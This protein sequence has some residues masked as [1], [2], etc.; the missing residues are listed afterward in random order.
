MPNPFFSVIVPTYNRAHLI[1]ETI[2]SVLA[3]TFKDFEL[4]IV[5]DGS[6]DN[7]KEVIKSYLSD[8]RVIYIYQENKERAAARNNGIRNS[9]GEWIALLDSDDLWLPNH[10]EVSFNTIKK[11]KPPALV[12]SYSYLANDKGNIISKLKTKSFEGYVLEQIIKQGHSGFTNSS[13]SI[14]KAI[15]NDVGLFNED[16]TLSGSEDTELWIRIASKYPFY[17]TGTYTVKLRRHSQQTMINPE[18]ME[19]CGNRMYE[20]I[21]V[22]PDLKIGHLKNIAKAH[23]YTLF[24]INYYSSGKMKDARERLYKAVKED[25]RILLN[26]RWWWIWLRTFIP[27]EIASWLRNI[28]YNTLKFFNQHTN[29]YNNQQQIGVCMIVAKYPPHLGGLE[30]QAHLL[31]KTLTQKGIEVFVLTRNYT[32]LK[33]DELVD[34]V[35]IH[36]VSLLGTSTWLASLSYIIGS[37]YWLLKNRKKYNIIHCHQSYSPMSIGIIAK[38]FLNKPVIVKLTSSMILSE[39]SELR[40]L[41]LYKIRKFFLKKVDKF[42]ALIPTIKE[43]AKRNDI[44]NER[45][46][47]IPNGVNIKQKSSYYLNN[48]LSA[49]G[50]IGLK[51]NDE[52]IVIFTG[53]LSKEKG[54]DTL[55]KAW[56][57]ISRTTKS[58]LFIVGED[59]LSRNIAN[60]IKA[61]VTQFDLENSVIFTGRVE[62]TT[63]YLIASDIFVLP[64]IV[65]GMSN[66]LLEAMAAGCAIIAS[67]IEPNKELIIDNINGLLFKVGNELAL[68]EKLITLLSNPLLCEKLGKTAK[69]TIIDS[70]SIDKVADK[71]IQLY[72]NLIDWYG[73]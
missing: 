11:I 39:F 67:D 69:Q 19:K 37:L 53:R 1:S 48:K 17:S 66:S 58:K 24:A 29:K 71:Y 49:R 35:N 21:F 8:P 6:T 52:K 61:L 33:K 10:L 44:P 70:Y 54:L 41:P 31:S 4:I 16:R 2:E 42:I 14:H 62:D 57:L 25:K 18:H 63:D 28:K 43:E 73:K 23:R 22:N 60:E 64:S 55:I 12:Y 13:S 47:I 27:K 45:V 51:K 59:D 34:G 38:L 72:H 68:S 50:A 26:R 7:T 15:L 65:E 20:I 56:S 5:D 30:R 40:R 3:Q 32:N 46:L 36:R 9:T